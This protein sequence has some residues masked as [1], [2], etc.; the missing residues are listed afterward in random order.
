[1][2]A[3]DRG[4]EA[5]AALGFVGLLRAVPQCVAIGF[6]LG[7][8]RFFRWAL[9]LGS[10]LGCIH[11]LLVRLVHCLVVVALIHR[12]MASAAR[13]RGLLV[14]LARRLVRFG[15]LIRRHRIATRR[16]LI[17]LALH[18]AGL[19]V[20]LHLARLIL[21]LHLVGLVGRRLSLRLL[22]H[23]LVGG[24]ARRIVALGL[25]CGGADEH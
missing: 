16:A 20:V 13:A 9:R 7:R 22:C 3:L 10:V 12:L 2:K 23:A 4:V 8:A 11:C 24:H 6:L 15:L 5:I 21:A 19:I 18:L 25:R 17:M 14:F 1:M